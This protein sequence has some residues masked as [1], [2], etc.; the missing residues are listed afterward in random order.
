MLFIT[1]NLKYNINDILKNNTI[2]LFK[3]EEDTT[4]GIVI[5]KV[6]EWK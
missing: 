3:T 5:E 1:K 4:T 6:W 2:G